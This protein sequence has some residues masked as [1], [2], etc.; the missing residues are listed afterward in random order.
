MRSPSLYGAL[1]NVTSNYLVDESLETHHTH[2]F[3]EGIDR[4]LVAPM[5]TD[6]REL[7]GGDIKAIC[8]G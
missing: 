4:S 3:F 7:I 1:P 2:E 8:G 5:H 6:R